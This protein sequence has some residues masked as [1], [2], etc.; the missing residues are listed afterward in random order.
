M[1]KGVFKIAMRYYLLLNRSVRKNK[2]KK[3]KK[4]RMLKGDNLYR[5]LRQ[6][7]NNNN[8]NNNNITIAF[9]M[10]DLGFQNY[11]II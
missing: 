5:D 2:Y 7:N 11:M 8:N 3:K 6:N 9:Q 4:I 10:V 1:Y